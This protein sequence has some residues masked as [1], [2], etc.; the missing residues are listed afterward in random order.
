MLIANVRFGAQGDRLDRRA[1]CVERVG[2]RQMGDQ[3]FVVGKIDRAE[4]RRHA[5]ET[6]AE[7]DDRMTEIARLNENGC[8]LEAVLVD[9]Q[10]LMPPHLS[11][12]GQQTVIHR[13]AECREDIGVLRIEPVADL[14]RKRVAM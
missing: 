10:G 11:Q 9:M 8:V 1:Q 7:L 12:R 6:V 3:S 5:V 13:I 14:L 2:P 4:R